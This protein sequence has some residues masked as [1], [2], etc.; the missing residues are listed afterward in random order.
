MQFIMEKELI[1]SVD[2]LFHKVCL[3]EF[4]IVT[5]QWQKFHF[6]NMNYDKQIKIYPNHLEWSLISLVIK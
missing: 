1:D 3:K 5:W 6:S 2:R 4:L